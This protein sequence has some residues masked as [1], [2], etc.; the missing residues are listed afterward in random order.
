VSD[1]KATLRD[2]FPNKRMDIGDDF[3]MSYGQFN[4]LHTRCVPDWS[5]YGL[6]LTIRLY[7]LPGHIPA[8][9]E[10]LMDSIDDPGRFAVLDEKMKDCPQDYPLARWVKKTD[11]HW[12]CQVAVTGPVTSLPFV[13]RMMPITSVEEIDHY[14]LPHNNLQLHEI[15]QLATDG[16]PEHTITVAD[17]YYADSNTR[18]C[19][20][21][22]DC[23]Y[24]LSMS[25]CMA[26][27]FVVSAI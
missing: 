2:H 23:Y 24:M 11:G 9:N 19:M 5:S 13:M 25:K 27:F 17:S 22:N 6:L 3:S 26:E 15:M 14:E 7:I 4:L 21:E 20:R 8:L 1:K 18:K 12:T 10:V 16:F